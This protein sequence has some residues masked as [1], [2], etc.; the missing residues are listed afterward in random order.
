MAKVSKVWTLN[1]IQSTMRADGSHWW[2][3]GTMR[4]FG[5]R[6]C[7]PAW[8][9]PNGVFFVTSEQPPHG[10]RG[11]TIRQ[12]V[13]PDG[14]IV[15]GE[16]CTI[17]TVG[18]VCGY[19]NRE[20]AIRNA[21]KLAGA[22]DHHNEHF[23]PVN[24]FEQFL[25]S[26]ARHGCPSITATE[27]RRIVRLANRHQRLMVDFCNGREMYGADDEPLPPLRR[28]R[29]ELTRLAV[30]IGCKGVAFSGDP[31]GCTVKLQLKDGHTDDWGKEGFCV[32]MKD[33]R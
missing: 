4:F 18:E 15:A 29:E 20:T 9:G 8:N 33:D 10:A 23:Q 21:R 11:Y 5:T 24:D 32:P 2:D 19:S 6:L 17:N 7:G 25:W 13:P 14:P 27:A 26:L 30:S 3:P 28:C 1:E 31:R 16:N 22:S 12:F